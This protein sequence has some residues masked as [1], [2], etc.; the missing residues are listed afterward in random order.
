MKLYYSTYG[1]REL[2]IFAVLPRLRDM[3]YEGMEI[4]V[5]PG[6]PTEP[7]RLDAAS[8]RRLARQLGD[9]NFP[10][11]P[12]MALLSPCATGAERPAMLQQFADTFDLALDLR[13]DDRMPVVSTTLGHP[14]S[15]WDSGKE[16]IADLVLEVA[17]LAAIRGVILAIEPHAGGD[18]ETPEKAAWLMEHTNHEHLKLNF[19]YSHF[20]VEGVDLQHCITLNLPY[21]VHNHIKDGYLDDGRVVYLLPGDGELDLA[22]YLQAMRDAGWNDM[23]VPE[24]TGMIWGK[25]G[26][27]PWGTAQFCF[28][29]LDKARS[30]L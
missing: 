12:L 17:D 30:S 10:T 8:R 5:T 18:F 16:Q 21:A 24:V 29:A 14:K 3:G 23:I 15:S 27:D 26:Y 28:A 2:D 9:L 11:P 22:V 25:E 19:D 7:A 4:A 20:W 6:W 1:M 13:L